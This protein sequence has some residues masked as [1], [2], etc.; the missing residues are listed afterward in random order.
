METFRKQLETIALGVDEQLNAGAKGEARQ[1]GFVMLVFPMNVRDGEVT[2][3]SNNVRRK[4]VLDLLKEQV[5][6]LEHSL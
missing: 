2:Y 3:L 1:F 5:I 6:R 4:H